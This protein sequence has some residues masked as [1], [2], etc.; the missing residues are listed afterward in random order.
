MDDVIMDRRTEEAPAQDA[1]LKVRKK[2]KKR[3]KLSFNAFFS[4]QDR[5]RTCT[6][7]GTRT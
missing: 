5:N 6:P 2:K 4:A 7:C 3:V 1:R